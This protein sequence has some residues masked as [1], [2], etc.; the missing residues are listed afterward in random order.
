MWLY[1]LSKLR[2]SWIILF[3]FGELN[4][5][6]LFTNDSKSGKFPL[7]SPKALAVAS[8]AKFSAATVVVAVA[9]SEL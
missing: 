8:V 7:A 9:I 1:Q 4:S 2:K 5:I 6:I 3:N